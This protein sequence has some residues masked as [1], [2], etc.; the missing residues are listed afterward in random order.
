MG[1]YDPFAPGPYAVKMRS[2]QAHDANRDRTFACEIWSA[3]GN[4]SLICYSHPSG[5]NRKSASFLCAHLA[6]HGYVVAAL[7]H[8]ETFA[9]DLARRPNETPEQKAARWEALIASRVPDVRFLLDRMLAETG[10]KQLGIVGHSFGGWTALTAAGVDERIGAVVA[11]APGGSSNPRPG[12]LPL[13]LDY[14]WKAPTLYLVAEGDT[15]MP[16]EGMIE[17]FEKTPAKKRMV[18]LRRADHMHFI[19]EVERLHEAVRTMPFPRELAWLQ[20]EIRPIAEL[21]SGEQAHLFARGLALC[22]F[23]SVL[24][25]SAEAKKFLTGD[26]RAEL[27]ARGVDA[28]VHQP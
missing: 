12:I 3:A 24:R 15:S 26:L 9:P 28:V 4:H 7:D 27:A 5:G 1:S 16:L 13:K 10:A 8:S 17:I 21:A 25:G 22:H 23:D 18:I 11:M 20:K 2:L 19:D 14:A 6:S